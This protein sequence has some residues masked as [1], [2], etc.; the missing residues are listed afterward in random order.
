MNA[1]A[2]MSDSLVN[3]DAEKAYLGAILKNNEVWH[4]R[5]DVLKPEHFADPL[6]GR[7]YEAISFHLKEGRIANPPVL[8]HQFN[9]DPALVDAG[10][11]RYLIDLALSVVVVVGASDYADTIIDLAERRA[12]AKVFEKGIGECYARA[13]GAS[14]ANIIETVEADIGAILD[15]GGHKATLMTA[16]GAVNAAI[17]DA[18]EAHQA[19]GVGGIRT[20]LIDLDRATGGL[21]APDLI[22]LAGRPGMGKTALADSI[23]VNVAK[24]GKK[25]GFFTLEMSNRQQGQRIIAAEAGVSVD[26]LRAGRLSQGDFE[27]L[28]DIQGEIDA[29]PLYFDDDA[30]VTAERMLSKAKRLQRTKGLDIIIIDYLQLMR[31]RK[32]A[33]MYERVTELSG[34]VK[35]MAK[36]L[37]VP[38]L[39]LSQLSRAVEQ[40]DDKRPQLADLRESGAIE[41]DADSVWF[42]Y[43]EAYYLERA[44]P[45]PREDEE[46][47]KFSA[48]LSQHQSRLAA[49]KNIGEVIIAKNRHGPLSTVQLFFDGP[50]SKFT[51]LQGN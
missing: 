48:R 28:A 29:L 14:A 36:L 35:A 21:Q 19:G 41:Q 9:G 38:V 46:M 2:P 10:G 51:N 37:H 47:H 45:K 34:A 24:R 1:L 42:A 40:R 5:A 4:G 31:G 49:V 32:G 17:E 27:A 43:R 6:H 33:T 22:I 18:K 39:C 23:A 8:M 16:A 11:A 30:T 3:Y 25:V 12:L 13:S 26:Q 50:R 7:I 15:A 20:G 44:E